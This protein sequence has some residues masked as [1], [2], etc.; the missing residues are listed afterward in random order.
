MIIDNVFH[1][2]HVVSDHISEKQREELMAVLPSLLHST[3]LP[4]FLFS[5]AVIRVHIC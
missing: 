3:A 4:F 5:T 1:L 2:K